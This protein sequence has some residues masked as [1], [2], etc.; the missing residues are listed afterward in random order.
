VA[1]PEGFIPEMA[2]S[3]SGGAR[4]LTVASTVESL[5]VRPGEYDPRPPDPES[6]AVGFRTARS[7][8]APRREVRPLRSAAAEAE[9]PG[10]ESPAWRRVV[11]MVESAAPADAPVLLLG[12]S[13][14]GKELLAR[15]LHRRSARAS[16]PFVLVNCAAVPL[17]RWES[18]FFGH[19]KGS[20]P[21][22]PGPRGSVPA[23]ERRHPP[24]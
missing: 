21:G 24:P 2:Y 20:F 10:G 9:A 1:K 3:V 13:G 8:R 19:R 23:G 7:A 18:E 16:G 15:L 4:D 22:A 11:A 14:T 5:L 17:E 12:E 6:P